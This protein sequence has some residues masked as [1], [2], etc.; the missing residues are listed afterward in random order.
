MA[1]DAPLLIV[2]AGPARGQ[3]AIVERTITIGR[4]TSSALCIADLALSRHHCI[5]ER[6]RET[7]VVRDL[8]SR[9]GTLVNGVPIRTHALTHGDQIRAGDSVFLYVAAAGTLGTTQPEDSPALAGELAEHSTVVLLADRND[10]AAA[11]LRLSADVTIRHA[12]IG[13]SAAMQEV[14]R[15]I[16]RV[17]PTDATALIRGES[18]T[19]KELVARAIHV[20]SARAAKPFVAINCAALPEGLL[21]SELFGHE[22]GAFT[23]AVAQKRASSWP[24]AARCSSTRSAS[25]RRRCKR[26]CCASCRSGNWSTWA[27]ADR[28]PWTCVSSPQPTAIWMRQSGLAPSGKISIFGSTSSP[29][30]CHRFASATGMSRYCCLTS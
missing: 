23:G 11:P 30:P 10:P 13:E 17:A 27:A 18:G 25:W 20:N 22:K 8:D 12:L 29:L 26:N 5:V 1:S 21:E 4:D 24:A 16:A 14:F 3:V 7:A 15:R 19:G 6:D 2:V 28:F 9:N